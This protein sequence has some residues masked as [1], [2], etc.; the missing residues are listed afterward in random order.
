[1][2]ANIKILDCT[3]RDGGYINNWEFG[4]KVISGTIEKLAM[5]NIEIIECG[6]I[7]NTVKNYDRAVFNSI[8]AFKKHI[9]PKNRG[10]MYVGM[11]AYPYIP[12]EMIS[13]RNNDSIDG[14]RVTFHENEIE[15]ALEYSKQLMEK[16]YKVFFQPIGTT[17]YSDIKLLN[18]IG[19]VNQ[20]KPYAFYLVDTLGVMYKND[21]LRMFH[22]LD[23]NLDNT[24][25][26]GYHSHNNLQLSFSNAQELLTLNT[27][28]EIIIDSSVFGMGRGAGN[29]CTELIAQY[30]NENI[31]YKYDVVPILEIYDEFLSKINTNSKWGY[32]IPYFLAAINKT[33]PNYA[34]Y[35][36]S[37]QTLTVNSINSILKKIPSNEKD[38]FNLELIENKYLV[39]QE[40]YLDDSEAISKLAEVFSQEKE[41]LIIAPGRT[42]KEEEYKIQK[43]I[44]ERNPYVISVNFIPENI[45]AHSIFISNFKRY[46]IL[47]DDIKSGRITKKIIVTSNIDDEFDGVL[48][49]NYSDLLLGNS[50]VSDNSGLM[51]LNLLKKINIEKVYI[52]GFDGY[53]YNF[54]NNYFAKDLH[55]NFYNDDLNLKNHLINIEIVN[56]TEEINIEFITNTLYTL[57]K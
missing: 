53:S 17:S 33:H 45:I 25:S 32:S 42:I 21:L 4:D 36:L 55:Y 27:K 5:A 8:E 10:V 3:L 28:R 47:K 15:E 40:K 2:L 26:I 44:K 29:L 18:L 12:I 9:Y 19:Y 49:V 57:K 13:P 39:Y 37:K 11:V 52:A 43:F 23:N 56:L 51:L 48:K 54:D 1:M 38:I 14:I 6:F 31:K 16:G 20:L 30:I 7:E 46:N 34:S 24:I 22:L 35:L 41:L 50:E